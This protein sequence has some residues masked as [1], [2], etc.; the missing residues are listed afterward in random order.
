MEVWNDGL[1]TGML[2]GWHIGR[3]GFTPLNPEPFLGDP[4]FFLNPP[5]FQYFIIPGVWQHRTPLIIGSHSRATLVAGI[6]FSFLSNDE[7]AASV[8][9]Q[10]ICQYPGCS[11]VLGR[12]VN[13]LTI[14]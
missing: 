14:L 4:G 6:R 5:L 13:G 12:Y 8:T 3:L 1:K 9:G 11:E 7:A 2:E 10:G